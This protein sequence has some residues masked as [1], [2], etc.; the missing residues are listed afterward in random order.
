MSQLLLNDDLYNLIFEQLDYYSKITYSTYLKDNKL[1]YMKYYSKISHPTEDD[2]KSIYEM[3]M[4]KFRYIVENKLILTC[5]GYIV[6]PLNK[7]DMVRIYIKYFDCLTD[8]HILKSIIGVGSYTNYLHDCIESG[9]YELFKKIHDNYDVHCDED[10]SLY[11]NETVFDIKFIDK[12]HCNTCLGVYNKCY[13]SRG[14]GVRRKYG[15]TPFSEKTYLTC[16]SSIDELKERCGCI[17]CIADIKE[18]CECIKYD[19]MVSSPEYINKYYEGSFQL[20]EN[21]AIDK[22][23]KKSSPSE[24]NQESSISKLGIGI[25]ALTIGLITTYKMFK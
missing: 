18:K 7:L 17:K 25:I 9:N 4:D 15:V 1:S 3:G 22:Y 2:I 20:S 10:F 6:Y 21:I 14:H 11:F 19:D 12:V 5:N 8:F 16:N 23:D 24:Y 13:K